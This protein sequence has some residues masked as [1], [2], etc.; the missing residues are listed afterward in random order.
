MTPDVSIFKVATNAEHRLKLQDD[1]NKLSEW[2]NTWLLKFLADK[3]KHMNIGRNKQGLDETPYRYK[4]N[5]SCLQ[6]VKEEKEIGVTIDDELR[7]KYQK[8]FPMQIA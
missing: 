7:K 2:S 5:D 3:C 8:K 4:L 1:L 6:T